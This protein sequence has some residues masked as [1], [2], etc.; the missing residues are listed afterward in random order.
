[1][2][3]RV[4][5]IHAAHPDQL[6]D[7]VF[8]ELSQ[9]HRQWPD[10]R[11][12]VLVPEHLKADM[13]R[14]Y[15][16]DHQSQGLMMAEVLSF[17]R[18]AARLAAEA[19][20]DSLPL[21]SK[22]GKAVLAQK[23]LLDSSLPFKR[24][25]RLAGRARYAQEL[26]NILG[27]FNRYQIAARDLRSFGDQS[28]GT[29]A[30]QATLEKLSDFA[31][32]KEALD[33]AMDQL[34]L[35]DPDQTLARLADLLETRP[36]HHRLAFLEKSQIWV[37][38]FGND[39]DFTSQ[40]RRL[41]KVLSG[42]LARLTLVLAA[43]EAGQGPLLPGLS[44]GRQSLDSL[45][46]LFPQAKIISL[47]PREK[48]SQPQ[49]RCI[50]TPDRR[51]EARFAAGEIRRLLL[52]GKVRRRE[53]GIALC[54]R[55]AIAPYLET[56]LEDY[57]V[58]AYMDTGRPL[59]NSSLVRM[60]TA[61]LALCQ[62]DF[63]FDD[64][65]DY[66][67][68]GLSGQSQEAID[69]FENAG[70]ALGWRRASDLRHLTASPQ[71]MAEALKGHLDPESP[72][73]LLVM[74]LLEDVRRL[75]ELGADMRQRRTGRQKCQGL[76]DFLLGASQEEEGDLQR[77]QGF[78]PHSMAG[79]VQSRRDQ[80][81]EA[82]RDDNARLLVSSWNA[83][84]DFLQ[85]TSDLLAD[86]RLSQ[87]HFS[88][89][90]AAG[91]E[92]LALASIP[93]GI[94]RVRVGSPAQ[95]ASW[96]CKV[97][98]ILGMTDSAFPPESKQEGYLLDQE[99]VFLSQET[100]KP[101]PNRKRDQ[102]AAQ[103]WLVQSLLE[104]PESILY[105]STPSL[106]PDSSRI[107]DEQVAKSQVPE[108]ILTHYGE[109][110][111]ARW[112]APKLAARM[113]RWNE[114]APLAWQ[115]ALTWLL[116]DP[117]PVLASADRIAESLTLPPALV[118]DSLK[119]RKSVSVSML[120]GFND[121]PFRFFTDYL[122]GAS[123]RPVAR[124]L[125]NLQGTLL[126]GLMES[127]ARDLLGQLQACDQADKWQ[128][129]AQ[130]WQESLTPAYLRPH[131]LTTTRKEAMAWYG[132]ASLAG[133]I[134]G[135]LI[136]RAADTLRALAA[137]NQGDDFYPRWLEWAFPPAGQPD[138]LLMAKGQ[139][140]KVRG[141]VDRIDANFQ[142]QF[143]IMDYK[144]SSKD[145]SWIDLADGTDFQLPFYKRA[146]EASYPGSWVESL[147]FVGWKT[148]QVY[149]LQDF[150][151][152]HEAKE[153]PALDALQKQKDLWQEDWVDRAALFA[154]K[155]AIQTLETVLEGRFPAKPLVRGSRQ[156]PCRYCPWHAACGYDQRLAR[157]QALGDRAPDREAARVKVLELGRGGD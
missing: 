125:P 38:G 16:T 23:A 25:Q 5:L 100:G 111:D 129:L 29:K 147:F 62:Y 153:N 127:A 101:F 155:K 113:L 40:E 21:I 9:S 47:P 139:S 46:D 73:G 61:F 154:E 15:L 104:R 107:Y 140:Y 52:E 6:V 17:N 34:G 138:Y 3:A 13:E 56:A 4:R 69:R 110:V 81:L 83:L 98:F 157:N 152:S 68:S 43:D 126:H 117:V 91:L 41:L 120:Q 94:D 109:K 72:P 74:E 87:A 63:S 78:S 121:C 58:H 150:Q 42:C 19:G 148:P 90:L 93:A 95:M 115:E 37:L 112:Y 128:A 30:R 64:L 151:G 50:R 67:K 54:E 105:L 59:R 14:R 66:Y 71:A 85:E 20:G 124:D 131:Y 44:R 28:Q 79:R 24:F 122:V 149:Q 75:L 123:E 134:G 36:L 133:G 84:I 146:F 102:P 22:A 142:G 1:M 119:A 10:H 53:I 2:S 89:M 49:V 31:L 80:L 82:K 141:K 132:E 57:G 143:R 116:K 145:F 156:N 103:A 32:L 92:G 135:R 114:K 136:R 51:E 7:L 65:L 27:D 11:A 144:R 97:L 35:L 86:A 99:R 70:L 45:K 88:D 8:G 106:G 12:F 108:T 77:D 26:V 48:P 60:L 33:Q 18:L 96:P 39:R 55:A 130:H 118:Q 137:F 76:L